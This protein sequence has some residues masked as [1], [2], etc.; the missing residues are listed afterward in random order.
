MCLRCGECT[1]KNELILLFLIL[2]IHRTVNRVMSMSGKV[3]SV[4]DNMDIDE[5]S[6]NEDN[7]HTRHLHSWI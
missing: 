5:Y 4:M 1:D 7:D 3:T 2:S 6:G